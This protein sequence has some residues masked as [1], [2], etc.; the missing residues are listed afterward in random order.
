LSKRFYLSGETKQET[1]EWRSVIVNA[2]LKSEV[3]MKYKSKA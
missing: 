2:A 3:L 1:E